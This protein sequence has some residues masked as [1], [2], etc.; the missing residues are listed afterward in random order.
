[1]R[2]FWCLPAAY[3][4]LNTAMKSVCCKAVALPTPYLNDNCLDGPGRCN[5]WSTQHYYIECQVCSQT[6]VL[7]EFLKR[8][9]LSG[10]YGGSLRRDVLWLIRTTVD[11]GQDRCSICPSPWN[12]SGVT[13]HP[14]K[15]VEPSVIL[16]A[17]MRCNRFPKEEG[18][19][20]QLCRRQGR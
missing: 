17:A 11:Q 5:A 2:S 12:A 10:K 20:A 18:A 16:A 9:G 14:W 6:L 19:A 13:S 8:K 7:E 4:T 15:T 1:M 3:L